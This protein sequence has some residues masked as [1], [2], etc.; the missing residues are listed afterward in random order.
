MSSK[1]GQKYIHAQEQK[2]CYYYN[3]F[4]RHLQNESKRVN[5]ILT[6]AGIESTFIS[7]WKP[8]LN[9]Y[10]T[11]HKNEKITQNTIWSKYLLK[12]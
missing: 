12:K 5:N 6:T 7:D 4:W 3:K 9:V 11:W 1:K 10:K 8:G 2:L